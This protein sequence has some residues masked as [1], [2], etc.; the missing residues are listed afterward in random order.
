[1]TT[2]PISTLPLARRTPHGDHPGRAA[3]AGRARGQHHHQAGRLAAGIAEGTVFRVFTDKSELMRACV[4][5]AFRTDRLCA[6]VG[7]IPADLPLPENLRARPERW[8]PSAAARCGR[9]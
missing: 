1:V 7:K 5:E 3:A 8:S 2:V 9:R 4:A 6:E